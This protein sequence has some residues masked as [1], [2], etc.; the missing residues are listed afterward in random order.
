MRRGS[1][2]SGGMAALMGAGMGES[3]GSSAGEPG[4]LPLRA[5]LAR[6]I[7]LC[8]VPLLL[9]SA[10]L[11]FDR[12]DS[13]RA[14]RDRESVNLAKNFATVVDDILQTRIAALN[15]LAL[16]PL[17]DDTARRKDLYHEAQGV[18]QSFGS[19]VIL[20]DPDKQI[21]FNTRLPFDAAPA[22]LPRPKGQSAVDTA[23]ATGRPAVGD[24]YFGPVAREMLVAVAVPALRAGVPQH[25]LLATL[26]TRQFQERLDLVALPADWSLALLDGTG[27]A[28]ARRGPASEAAAGNAEV[29]NAEDSGRIVVPSAFA[30]WSV[31]L[32]IPRASYRASLISSTIALTFAIVLAALASLLGGA[33]AGRRLARSVASLTEEHAPG[34]P[35]PQFV[36]IAEIDAVRARLERADAARD[37]AEA[38]L[39]ASEARY[40]TLFESNLSGELLTTPDGGILAAN[41]AAQRML[42]Y[43]EDELRSL[44]RAGVVDTSDPRLAGALAERQRT[45][46]FQG[47]LTMIRKGGRRFPAELSSQIFVSENGMTMSSMSLRDLTELKCAEDRLRRVSRGWRTISECNQAMA[48]AADEAALVDSVCRLLVDKGGYRMVWVGY[49]ENDAQSSVRLVATAGHDAGYLDGVRIAWDDSAWGRGPTGSAIR[50]RHPVVARYLADETG[51]EPWRAAAL[52]RGYASSIA[53]PLLL[54]EGSDELRCLGAINLYAAET[55]VFDS[56]EIDLLAELAGDLAYGIGALRERSRRERSEAA[57]RE[58]MARLAESQRIA[59]VGSW[60]I[61]LPDGRLSWSEEMYRLYGVAPETFAH[62]F[63]AFLELL[64]PDDRTAMQDWTDACLAGGE[65]GDLEFRLAGAA[66]EGREATVFRGRGRLLYAPDGRPLRMTGTVQDITAQRADARK[67]QVQLDELLRWQNLMLGREDRILEL[68]AEVNDLLAQHGAPPRY[69]NAGAGAATGGST[70][71]I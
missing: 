1:S 3:V 40:R 47:E 31:A 70:E 19:H 42:G 4:A 71:A 16:S 64:H 55:D 41:P 33:W 57:L 13:I 54:D 58:Q 48:R 49:A 60:Q 34:V 15:V 23:L 20:A 63:A 51:F 24:P 25:I 11:A 35:V 46:R 14:R 8:V 44:G 5:F 36:H 65:P 53:V 69:S 39:R 29:Q 22:K 2:D 27:A 50:E 43:S 32:S 18:Q 26:E 62:T 17:L 21:L 59:H 37:A 52:Q 30:P 12:V 66:S 28:I 10:Y 38:G 67:M 61:D 9:V 56:D 45:G 68:K 7:W 6:L